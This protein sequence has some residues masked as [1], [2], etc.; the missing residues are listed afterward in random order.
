M[1]TNFKPAD[2]MGIRHTFGVDT[3]TLDF[4]PEAYPGYLAPVIRRPAGE[5]AGVECIA[6]RFGLI[7]GWAKDDTIGRKTYNARTETVAEKP[8]YRNAWNRRQVCLAPMAWF[9]EPN[10]ES[11]KA[12]RWRIHRQDDAC[13]AVAGIWEQWHQAGV[14]VHSFSLL[15]INAD[16]DPLMGR[17]HKPE[18]EKRSLVIIPPDQYDA[19]LSADAEMARTFF[20]LT[21]M[22]GFTAGAANKVPQTA[23]L[24]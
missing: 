16:G 11:G 13:F 6:A 1:C 19:W 2:Q 12:E 23:S 24:F 3:P 5:S 14:P 17:F 15:T 8:S 4:K 9:V 18:D 10:Y 7:P 21:P 22:L 20:S